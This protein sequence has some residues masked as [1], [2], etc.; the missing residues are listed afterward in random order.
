MGL[1]NAPSEGL[2]AMK[3]PEASLRGVRP[4]GRAVGDIGGAE[5]CSEVGE[6]ESEYVFDRDAPKSTT[7]VSK[8]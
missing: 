6:A 5:D 3:S 8:A 4:W 7:G 2:S 1:R